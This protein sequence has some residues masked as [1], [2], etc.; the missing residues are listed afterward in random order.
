MFFKF[1]M[2][3]ICSLFISSMSYA[4]VYQEKLSKCLVASTTEK[5]KEDLVEWMFL[6]LATYPTMSKYVT[7]SS[8]D[9]EFVDRNAAKIFQDLLM[10]KCNSE[11]RDVIRYEGTSALESSFGYL[12]QTATTTLLTDPHVE[13]RIKNFIKYIDAKQFEQS[14]D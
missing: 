11:I 1:S 3:L 6:A 12:G 10:T 14:L 4:G 9:L 7:I 2:V 8:N 13:N 5:N